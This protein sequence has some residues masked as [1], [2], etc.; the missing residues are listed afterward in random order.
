MTDETDSAFGGMPE[1]VQSDFIREHKHTANTRDAHPI[2]DDIVEQSVET[3][4]VIDHELAALQAVATRN[5]LELN[6]EEVLVGER[7]GTYR[8]QVTSSTFYSLLEE[9]CDRYDVHVQA[10]QVQNIVEA[11]TRQYLRDVHGYEEDFD[12]GHSS[13][14]CEAQNDAH[15]IRDE[16]PEDTHYP[17]VDSRGL[18]VDKGTHDIVTEQHDVD[19]M[20]AVLDDSDYEWDRDEAVHHL[21]SNFVTDESHAEEAFEVY[22]GD[23]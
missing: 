21:E 5:V 2:D 14:L 20:A 3:P 7:D 13:T 1:I 8:F 22:A 12:T 6:D 16:E 23:R 17:F 9:M 11:H 19:D 15:W 18:V 10:E 4:I